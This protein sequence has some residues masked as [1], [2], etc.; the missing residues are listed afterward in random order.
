MTSFIDTHCHLDML[1]LEANQAVQNAQAAKVRNLVTI[2]VDVASLDFVYQAVQ[3]WMPVYGSVGIHPHEAATYTEAVGHKIRQL[4]ESEKKIIAI[5]ETG[6]DYHYQHSP[7]DAQHVAFKAQLQIA[8]ALGLPIVLHSREAEEDTLALLK[9]FP[10][11]R[12]G[13]AHSFTGSLKMAQALVELGWFI[14]INGIITFKN[15][16]DLRNV[17][18]AL[19]LEHLLLETDAPFLTPVPYRGTPNDP[20]KIPI[21]AQFI[22]QERKISLEQLAEQT[23]HN[24]HRLFQVDAFVSS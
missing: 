8:E 3:T 15:A 5:G 19:P 4:A 14:G 13:V 2:A 9:E 20:S 1:K 11:S 10:V 18:Q 17:V 21:I 22:A 6:L 23:N 7:K 12:K 24:A 16:Q